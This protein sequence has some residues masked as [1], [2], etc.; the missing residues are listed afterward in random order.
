LPAL[1]QITGN[2]ENQ[3]PAQE[4]KLQIHSYKV[5]TISGISGKAYDAYRAKQNYRNSTLH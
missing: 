5:S 3:Q 4:M 2:D 1:R